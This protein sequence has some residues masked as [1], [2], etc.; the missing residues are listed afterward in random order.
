MNVCVCVCVFVIIIVAE[1]SMEGKN[2]ALVL[3]NFSVVLIVWRGCIMYVPR[4][5]PGEGGGSRVTAAH[6]T[7]IG[8]D[9]WMCSVWR[10]RHACAA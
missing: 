9:D 6:Y 7:I 5:D 3:A 8:S 10:N 1:V 2:R 4:A